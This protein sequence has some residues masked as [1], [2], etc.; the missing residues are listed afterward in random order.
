M[1][2]IIV[3]HRDQS[4]FASFIGLVT[5]A[6]LIVLLWFGWL[7]AIWEWIYALLVTPRGEDPNSY[8]SAPLV[9]ISY[10][11]CQFIFAIVTGIGTT[12]LVISRWFWAAVFDVYR[13]IEMVWLESKKKPAAPAAT[14][15]PANAPGQASAVQSAPVAD[16]VIEMLKKMNAN[17]KVVYETV[18]THGDSI[19]QVKAIVDDLALRV[20]LLETNATQLPAPRAST[21]RRRTPKTDG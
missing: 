4:G 2:R 13:G 17:I 3:E 5:I 7:G 1:R 20:E 14:T 10:L 12:V 18:K 8:A 11:F 21:G 19:Q 6:A 15:M 9:P 16:P